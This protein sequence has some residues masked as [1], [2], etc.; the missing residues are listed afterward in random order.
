MFIGY[1]QNISYICIRLLQSK[2][3]QTK[4][5]TNKEDIVFSRNT[6]EFVTVA[7][8]YCAYIERANKLTRKEFTNT[9]LKLLPLLYIKA[10]MM[11]K[12]EKTG[13]DELETFLTE[14]SYEVIRLTLS[15]LLAQYDT[16]LDVFVAEMKYSDTPV[17]KNISEDLADIYQDV[18]NFVIQFQTGIN[19][20]MHDAI[21]ECNEHFRLYWGQTLVNTLRALH[22]I[23]YGTPEENEND[24]TSENEDF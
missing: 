6:V 22:E 12:A 15:D 19:E 21:V 9:L 11:P 2:A 4:T 13:E 24:E 18:K 20:T 17:T 16:Y 7:A 14:D 8:E 3:E 10:Q 5:M 1:L 23:E